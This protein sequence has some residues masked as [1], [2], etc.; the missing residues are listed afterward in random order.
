LQIAICREV[1]RRRVEVIKLANVVQYG[2][3]G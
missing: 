2:Q 3:G 1:N